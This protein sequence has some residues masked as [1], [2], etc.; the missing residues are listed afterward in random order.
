MN[1][2]VLLDTNIVVDLF[3]GNAAVAQGLLEADEVFVP[4]IVLG[5]L[6]FGAYHSERVSQN[7]AVIDEFARSNVVLSCDRDTARSYGIIKNELRTK[8]RPIPENDVWIAAI[9][10]QHDLTL[11]SRDSHFQEIDVIE[12]DSW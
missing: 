12:I 2:S 11:I 5:E 10:H 1:G 3:G 8:G 6:Y 7:L 9:A 4:S